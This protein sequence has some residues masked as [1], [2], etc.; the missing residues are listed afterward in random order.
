MEPSAHRA[1]TSVCNGTAAGFVPVV[2]RVMA[3]ADR[4]SP[5]PKG[6]PEVIGA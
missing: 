5:F 6:T 2:S 3:S 1:S 4:N